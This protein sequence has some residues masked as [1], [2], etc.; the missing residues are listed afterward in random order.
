MIEAK[1]FFTR[2]LRFPARKID[3]FF[4]GQVAKIHLDLFQLELVTLPTHYENAEI[5]NFF[6]LGGSFRADPHGHR[7]RERHGR[8]FNE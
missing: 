1:R 6:G 3:E 5:T 8:F 2:L 7:Q 4:A